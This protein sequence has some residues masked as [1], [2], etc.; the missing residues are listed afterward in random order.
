MNVT[1][2]KWKNTFTRLN[3]VRE[4]VMIT[5]N[6]HNDKYVTYQSHGEDAADAC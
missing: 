1:Q 2:I 3:D 6:R 5:D 4:L